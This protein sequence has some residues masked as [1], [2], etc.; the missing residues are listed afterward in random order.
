M[1]DSAKPTTTGGQEVDY[2][3][4]NADVITKYKDAATITQK[5]LAAVEKLCVEGASVVSIC[6]QGDAL[7]DEE[8]QKIYKGKK[9][10]KGIAFPTT[11]SPSDIVTPYSPLK[12]D[13]AEAAR[14]LKAGEIAKIQLGAHIDG[15]PAVTGTTIVVPASSGETPALT[16][17]QANLLLATHY[18]TELLTRLLLP[19]SVK[20]TPA[21]EGEDA[22][23]QKPYTSY[24]INALVKKICDTFGV[25]SVE[26][27]STYQF[28]RNEIEGKKRVVL[29]PAEGVKSE[30]QSDVNEAW[31]V[32]VAISTGS[33]KLKVLEHRP[34]LFKKTGTTYMFKRQ[35][36][37]QT[38]GEIAKKFGTFP[39]SLRQLSD[40]RTAKMGVVEAVRTNV[41]R[42]FEVLADKDTGDVARTFTTILITKNGITRITNPLQSL[43][44]IAGSVSDKKITDEEIL[45]ILEQPLAKAK[46]PKNKK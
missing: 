30:G 33:G 31:G 32:E 46:K 26:S 28:E 11:V 18:V 40:E 27:T 9:I 42:Q 10:S 8:I 45:K 44:D 1:A 25:N 13:V 29:N 41:L 3:L 22:K 6:E 23:E 24:Q 21:A 37:K 39:F 36:S 7:L 43:V 34:T 12:T 19:P 20:I 35:T 16:E 4:A 2:T 14:V 38:Y 15:F 5:V 17:A